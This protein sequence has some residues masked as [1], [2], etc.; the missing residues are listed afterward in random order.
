MMDGQRT[1]G[2]VMLLTHTLTIRGSGVAN[3][4]EFRPL[5][6]EEIA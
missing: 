6:W 1:H 4:V 2:K 3:L 5:V